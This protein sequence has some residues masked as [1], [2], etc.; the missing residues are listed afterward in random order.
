V[1]DGCFF[2]LVFLEGEALL[3]EM[4]MRAIGNADTCVSVSGAGE[5]VMRT[6]YQQADG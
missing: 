5:M 4:P 3:L 6:Q 1:K 2:L